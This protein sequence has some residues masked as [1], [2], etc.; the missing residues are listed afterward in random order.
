MGEGLR[1]ELRRP[2]RAGTSRG[3]DFATSCAASTLTVLTQ[4][5]LSERDT[6]TGLQVPLERHRAFL[7]GELDDNVQ[8]PTAAA[9]GVRTMARIVGRQTSSDV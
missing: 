2:V 3:I 5:P 8:F 6:R 4:V 1:G 9:R 7:V